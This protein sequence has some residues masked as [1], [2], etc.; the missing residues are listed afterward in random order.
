MGTDPIHYLLFQQP[1]ARRCSTRL[2]YQSVRTS[3][4]GA[5][6][7]RRPHGCG[8]RAYRDVYTARTGR[9]RRL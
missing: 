7:Y 2:T 4:D 8:R 1:V 5:F 3:A 6:R 9:L